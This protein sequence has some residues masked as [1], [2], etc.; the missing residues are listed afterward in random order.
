MINFDVLNTY[1]DN[2]A[3]IIFAVFTTYMEDYENGLERI[4]QLNQEQNWP[5]LFLLS[6]SLKSV[7]SSF[8][9]DSAV[10]ALKNIE[11]NTRNNISPNKRDLTIINNELVKINQQITDYLSNV[12]K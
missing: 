4:N 2:D 7:L 9:E 5:D 11:E 12:D 10:S 6:H 3:N 8:G 1:V